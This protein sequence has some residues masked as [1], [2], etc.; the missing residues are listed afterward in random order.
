MTKYDDSFLALVDHFSKHELVE[1]I[2]LAG[3]RTTA[4]FDKDSDYDLYIYSKQEIPLEFREELADKYFNY[5]ELD[6]RTWEQEDQ[7]F[8]KDSNVQIDIVY[9]DINWLEGMLEN[10]VIKHQALTGY[11]TCFWS[12]L[13]NSDILY[14]EDGELQ[15]LKESFD[16][17]YPEELRRNIIAKNYPILNKIIPAYTNQIEKALKRDDIISL[18]H[19]TSAFFES[20]FDIIFALNKTLHPGE[21]KLLKIVR[22]LEYTPENM[23]RDIRELF[24]NLYKKDFDVVD[25][26]NEIT[27]NLALLLRELRML[28]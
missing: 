21:K 1:G 19:R 4:N 27:N 16:I 26:L 14:D 3:S 10:I 2:M 18:N 28:D 25:K 20:Y 9:R 7:G 24:D 17:E 22:D 11:T 12:N 23:E 15:V 6:N 8:F 5:A 13:I